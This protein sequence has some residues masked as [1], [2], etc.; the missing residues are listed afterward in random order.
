MSNTGTAKP[1]NPFAALVITG[2][3]AIDSLIRYGLVAALA[4]VTGIIG[5]WLNRHGMTDPNLLVMISGGIASLL[6]ALVMAA[7]GI[8]R[9]ADIGKIIAVKEAAAVQAGVNMTVAGQALDTNGNV[10]SKNDGTTPPKPVTVET[11]KEIIANFAPP[12]ASV[13]AA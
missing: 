12:A 1:P 3:P 5:S 2:N 6:G 11:A 4:G 9:S 7:W 13:K 10:V 8:L